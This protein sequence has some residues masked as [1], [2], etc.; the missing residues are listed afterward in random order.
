M[1]KVKLKHPLTGVVEFPKQQAINI[2]SMQNNGGWNW[3]N[4]KDAKLLNGAIDD[5][6]SKRVTKRKDPSTEEE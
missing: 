1:D 2:M 5:N 4:K 3:N 6:P